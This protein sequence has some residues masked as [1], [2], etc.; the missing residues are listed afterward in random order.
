MTCICLRVIVDMGMV[1]DTKRISRHIL[2]S[3][4]D[5]DV[6]SLAPL[7]IVGLEQTIVNTHEATLR[8]Q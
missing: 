5:D 8:Q 1:V 7:Y 6:P 2:Y 3:T 4:L